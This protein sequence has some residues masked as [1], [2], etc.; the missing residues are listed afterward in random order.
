MEEN[1]LLT[2]TKMINI[3]YIIKRDNQKAV[4][5]ENKI[6]LA[7]SNAFKFN[8]LSVEENQQLNEKN[9]SINSEIVNITNDVL[10]KINEKNNNTKIPHVEKIQD[11]VER[12]IVQYNYPSIAKAYILYREK[13]REKREKK[14]LEKIKAHKLY[15]YDENDQKVVFDKEIIIS[16]IIKLSYGLSNINIEE[17]V[18]AISKAVFDGIKNDELYTIMMDIAKTRIEEHYDYSF[19]ASRF[20]LDKIYKQILGCHLY[21]SNLELLYKEKFIKYIQIGKK[22]KLFHESIHSHFNLEKIKQLIVPNRDLEFKFLGLQTLLDRYL[23]KRRE[24]QKIFE[25]PQWMWMRVAMGLCV[26]EKEKIRYSHSF[27]DVMSQFYFIPSTPTLFNAGTPHTQ[28]SSCYLNTIPDSLDDIFKVFQDNAQLS[29]WAGGIGTDWTAV[30][31]AGAYIKGTN[32]KSSGIIPFIKIFNDIAVAVNQGGKRKGAMAAYLENWHIDIA[33]FIEL[34]KNTGDDRRRAHDIHPVVWISDLFMKRVMKN[35]H[36]TLFSP[37]EVPEMHDLYGRDFENYYIN[38]EK[39][40]RI[41]TKKRIS[42][43]NLWRKILTMLY[44]TGHPWITFKCTS[45]IRNPQ[46]HVGVIHSSNLCTEITLNTSKNETAVCNLASLNLSKMIQNNALNEKL[47]EKTIEIGVRMLDNVIDNNFYP[48]KEAKNSNLKH[49]PIGLGMMGY[50]DALYQLKLPFASRENLQFSDLSMEM[51][52]YYAIK[53]SINLSKERGKYSSFKGSK[54]DRGIFPLDTLNLLE[55]EREAPITVSRESRMDWKIL[56]NELKKYG[57]RNSNLLAIAPTA[58]ISNIIGVIPCVEPV[59]K[60]IYMKENLSGNFCIINTSLVNYLQELG[61]WNRFILNK[62]KA[63]NGSIANIK[64]IPQEV[65]NIFKEAFEIDQSWILQAA[66]L[67]SKWIDQSASTNIFL[68]TTKGSELAKI[69]Q[70]AWKSGLKTTY[71][72]RTLAFSQV[73]K[74]TVNT[75]PMNQ[76]ATMNK[77]QSNNFNKNAFKNIKQYSEFNSNNAIP[78]LCSIDESCE[79]CQ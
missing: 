20:V 12:T 4:F 31:G 9:I 68:T 74:M 1:S 22:E 66:S 42:A 21:D 60:N 19:L 56:K 10:K 51:V 30:R 45:N 2:P 37:N 54:W 38:A 8:S 39:D 47:I 15:I 33:D 78:S 75:L 40:T 52:S 32:G 36:W 59:Y 35:E 55:K 69:Y 77:E 7:I 26:Q 53:A 3:D 6:H 11:L 5:N 79:V 27:Y 57:I 29:K 43:L 46:D 44:E 34:R 13:H 41:K 61:L 76:E 64:E 18:S 28:M 62:I 24:S 63:N 58:T 67:R 48:T 25:L 70:Q 73:T 49:R 14:V 72:L 65:R 17:I 50:Q 23:L 16:R 71:Y